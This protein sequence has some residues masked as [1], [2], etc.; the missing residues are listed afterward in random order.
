MHL[1]SLLSPMDTVTVPLL[2]SF[3]SSSSLFLPTLHALVLQALDSYL[4]SLLAS[5]QKHALLV[6]AACFQDCPFLLED[7]AEY[8]FD[9][10]CSTLTTASSPITL[11]HTLTQLCIPQSSFLQRFKSSVFAQAVTLLCQFGLF[12]Q[13][14]AS[15]NTHAQ[16]V[17][18]FKS[19][20]GQT[21]VVLVEFVHQF[22]ETAGSPFAARLT[23][24][25]FT[26]FDDFPQLARVLLFFAHL[27]YPSSSSSSFL[28]ALTRKHIESVGVSASDTFPNVK[29]T[30]SEAIRH[31]SHM[32][33][34]KRCEYVYFDGKSASLVEMNTHWQLRL[35]RNYTLSLETLGSF[36]ER[37]ASLLNDVMSV[38]GNAPLLALYVWK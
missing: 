18:W 25:Y 7:I 19:E 16:Q 33:V 5:D 24:S 37:V 38:G 23:S 17:K 26:V 14:S 36:G 9:S 13:P 21:V 22:I 2:T 1:S 10:L 8:V 6:I 32:K 28:S 35:S 11:F 31:L 12:T 20:E 29:Q 4:S 30:V 34:L 27:N 15:L 3:L